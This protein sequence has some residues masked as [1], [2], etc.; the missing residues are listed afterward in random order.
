MDI[1]TATIAR[2][3]ASTVER[4]IFEARSTTGWTMKLQ[5]FND[6]VYHGGNANKDPSD[7][8]SDDTL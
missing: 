5:I 3:M 2:Q 4:M 8:C 1:N 7:L 6:N